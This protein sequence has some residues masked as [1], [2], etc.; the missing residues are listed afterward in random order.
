MSYSVED[1]ELLERYFNLKAKDDFYTFRRLMHPKDKTG[2]FYKDLSEHFQQFYLDLAAGLRPNLIIQSPPQH[3]K[4]EAIVDFTAWICGKNPNLKVIFASFSDTLSVRA[5]LKMQ[6]MLDSIR[7]QKIFGSILNTK[8]I[9]TVSSQKRRNSNLIEFTNG[10]GYFRNTTVNGSITGESLDLGVI[11]DPVKGREAANSPTVRDKTWDWYTNDF[12]TRFSEKAGFLMILTRWHIDDLA[13]RI[14]ERGNAKFLK[15]KAIAEKNEEYRSEGEAL[16]PEHKSLEFLLNM[17]KTMSIHDFESLYQQNPVIEGGNLFKL[18]WFKPVS[19][20]VIK[21]LT[22][23]KYFIIADTAIGTKQQNDYTVYT[24]FG[25][26][27]NK[28]YVLDMYRGKIESLER[29]LNARSFY[30]RNNKYP[31]DGMYV[32]LKASGTDL[33][34]RLKRDSLM[35]RGIERD[36]DKITRAQE[37]LPYI[38]LNGIYYIDDV[39]TNEYMLDEIVSFPNGVHDDMVDTIIDGVTIA[40]NP[41]KSSFVFELA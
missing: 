25:V 17:K 7:Y 24:A 22:F 27:D 35:V 29:E 33:Y 1:V 23:Q 10:E 40:Y 32:E 34:Q 12:R 15:Y 16:F 37:V 4:S 26:S 31:F 21:T 19:R 3:G 20:E 36:K 41:P 38:E 14:K 30:K 28:L 2:W 9:T 5:N 39:D 6:R 18:E 11:D 13:G 8:N